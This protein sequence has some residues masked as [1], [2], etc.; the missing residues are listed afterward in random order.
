MLRA[1][2]VSYMTKA[3]RKAIM[4]SSEFK[5][6]NV[7]NKTNEN[8]KSYK[9][10]QKNFCSKLYKKERKKYHEMLDLNNVNDNKKTWKTVKPFLSDKVTAFLEISLAEKGK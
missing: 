8:L 6:K 10:N 5:N 3:L 4:K 9:K 1:N 7:K 2:H